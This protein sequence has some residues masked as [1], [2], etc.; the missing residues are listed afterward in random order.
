MRRSRLSLV[1]LPILV[2]CAVGC[3]ASVQTKMYGEPLKIL[4]TEKIAIINSGRNKFLT[5]LERSLR[6]TSPDI[7]LEPAGRFVD[8]MYPWFEP[9]IAPR[10]VKDLSLLLAQP[11]VRKEIEATGVRYIVG[12]SG[13]TTQ[14]EMSGGILCGG[15]YGGAGC[16]GVAWEGR[17]TIV[18][19]NIWD[20][21]ETEKKSA[22][23][24]TA[25]GRNVYPALL[26]PVPFLVATE[27]VACDQLA[28]ELS[29]FFT[30]GAVHPALREDILN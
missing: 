5:C 21:H 9:N 1:A 4:P 25:T 7:T 30:G 6:E 20:V 23:D 17:E 14:D 12:V 28:V 11:K 10:S 19:V 8:R 24:L 29:R 26:L 22:I 2:A 15:G 13:S 16:F 18:Q 3:A 27:S